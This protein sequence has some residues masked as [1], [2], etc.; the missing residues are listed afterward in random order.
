MHESG[1]SQKQDFPSLVAE[2][3]KI[4]DSAEKSG[5][6]LRLM[7]GVAIKIHTRKQSDLHDRLG[8]S[9]G[10]LDFVG[11]KKQSSTIKGIMETLGYEPNK[12]IN[13]YHGYKRQIWYSKANQIDI[14]FD[15][16]EMNHVID[17]K[18][19]LIIDRPTI[20]VSDLFLQKIQ[21]VQMNEKDLKDLFILLAEHDLGEDDSDKINL[22][23]VSKL[24]S[25]DWGFWY[26]T[27]LNLEKLNGMLANYSQ[28][29]QDEKK[30]ISTK[31]NAILEKIKTSP[32]SFR[33]KMR[34]KV[35]AKTQ[36]YNLVEE[37]IR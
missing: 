4:I 19:R 23:Y 24:L 21:I 34:S 30:S 10:D 5:A 28:L 18:D 25:E 6:T 31:T 15:I 11:L 1:V 17:L 14:L 8:R 32:K 29:S 35:G 20:D 12:S 7:G 2:G 13:A 26:T 37:V 36:W 22:D 9:P 3:L 16:F 27:V 33:W